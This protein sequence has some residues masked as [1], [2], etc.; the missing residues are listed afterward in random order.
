M[1]QALARGV[2]VSYWFRNDNRLPQGRL[3]VASYII[4]GMIGV[5]LLGF[6]KL[7]VIDAD[8][9][10][11]MAERNRVREIPVIAPRGR[12]LDRD[13]RVLL[14]SRQRCGARRD[15][16]DPAARRVDPR[17]GVP[18]R[19]QRAHESFA[20]VPGSCCECEGLSS[21]CNQAR[22]ARHPRSTVGVEMPMT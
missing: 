19:S 4:V 18:G 10:S 3:A 9:Y 13:G 2:F 12:M 20:I 21:V 5:L 7:Q 15:P 1:L 6:W 14:A 8:K 17:P 16:L 22:A 11:S